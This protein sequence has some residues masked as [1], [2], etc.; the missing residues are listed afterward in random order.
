M[1]CNILKFIF[2][3]NFINEFFATEIMKKY[4][5]GSSPI[6]FE[7]KKFK[8]GEKMHFKVTSTEPIGNLNYQYYDDIDSLYD[9]RKT[10]YS[11]CSLLV[12]VESIGNGAITYYTKRFTITKKK[13]EI[14]ELTGNYVL[15]NVEGGSVIENTRFGMNLGF[16]AAIC[17]FIGTLA[18]SIIILIFN[19]FYNKKNKTNKNVIINNNIFQSR[20]NYYSKIHINSKNDKINNIYW[21]K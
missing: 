12:E 21:P 11:V 14:G 20:E 4:S 17:L 6:I 1:S 19:L 16:L 7:S 3:V 2:F 15:L 8:I 10:K 13:E 18:F 5:I 9:W